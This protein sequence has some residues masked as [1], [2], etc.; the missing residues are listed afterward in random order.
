MRSQATLAFLQHLPSSDPLALLQSSIEAATNRWVLVCQLSW[1]AGSAR[2][3]AVPTQLQCVAACRSAWCDLVTGQQLGSDIV[4]CVCGAS[5]YLYCRFVSATAQQAFYERA[6][7]EFLQELR[8][9]IASD[10]GAVIRGE[11]LALPCEAW[12]VWNEQPF[13]SFPPNAAQLPPNPGA[14]RKALLSKRQLQQVSWGEECRR[15]LNYTGAHETILPFDLAPFDTE[16]GAGYEYKCCIAY[17]P[18]PPASIAVECC[19][20]ASLCFVEVDVS[21][22]LTSVLKAF[23][24]TSPTATKPEC[25]DT[26]LDRVHA[27]EMAC[28]SLACASGSFFTVRSLPTTTQEAAAVR[29]SVLSTNAAI[30]K[31]VKRLKIGLVRV[32]QQVVWCTECGMELRCCIT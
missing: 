27:Q 26:F 8:A 24:A 28:A 15:P 31:R 14:G 23:F 18:P 10:P 3:H 12:A 9:G 20:T 29:D 16:C 6:V 30:S 17:I 22:R 4:T 32:Y 13:A 19:L 2:L 25:L 11:R 21:G 5:P 1:P 7:R